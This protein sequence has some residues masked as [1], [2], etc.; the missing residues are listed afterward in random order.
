[1]VIRP[2]APPLTVEEYK[3]PPETGPRYQLAE[4]ISTWHRH[5]TVFIRTFRAIF[6]GLS[7]DT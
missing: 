1:M 4:E 2:H 3:S 7:I 6:R 5:E